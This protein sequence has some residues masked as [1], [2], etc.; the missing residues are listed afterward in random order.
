MV[1]H[2]VLSYP[3]FDQPFVLHTDAS[4]QGLGAVLEQEQEDGQLHPIAYASRT[5]SPTE[6]RYGITDLEA[7]ALVWAAKHF[8]AYL[9]GQPAVVY[10]DHAP[11][12]AMFRAKHSSGKLARWAGVIAELDLDI[13]Y[14]PGRVN[15]NADALSRSP[16]QRQEDEFDVPRE[17]MQVTMDSGLPEAQDSDPQLKLIRDYLS[18]GI[19]PPQEDRAKQLLAERE[20]F[21]LHD[22]VLYYVGPGPQRK[23]RI[24]VPQS[25]KETLMAES[26]SGPFGGHFAAKGLYNTLRQHYW[27]DRMFSDT[28]H[29]CRGCLTC[30]AYQGGGRRP[31]P[32]L[33]PIPVGGPFDRTCSL[34]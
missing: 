26:H 3:R 16:L 12:Q 34:G 30:A 17:I 27:W 20:Q 7:L 14:R 6:A 24:V 19:L 33:Q 11:L 1:T 8:R 2:P 22:N 28:M 13:R 21:T 9:L 25:M 4:G 10:T 32:P 23:L 18:S 15:S 5:L 31:R 29:H